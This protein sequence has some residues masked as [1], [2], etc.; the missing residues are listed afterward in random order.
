[1]FHRCLTL[2]TDVGLGLV[3]RLRYHVVAELLITVAVAG[4][5]RG[6][7]A[8]RSRRQSK[9]AHV[10]YPLN[11]NC[12]CMYMHGIYNTCNYV[13]VHVHYSDVCVY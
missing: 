9:A 6:T 7:N 3:G 8:R 1:M 11:V 2:I 12:T 13:Y 5:S 4:L 10:W